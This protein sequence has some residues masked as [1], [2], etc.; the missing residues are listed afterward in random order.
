MV[1]RNLPRFPLY[2]AIPE[3]ELES[4]TEDIIAFEFILR[5]Y[6][7]VLTLEISPLQIQTIWKGI[8]C[9]VSDFIAST[10][11]PSLASAYNL[12]F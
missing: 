8:S 10:N 5:V 9:S 7:T 4:F 2:M 6:V 3:E 1:F 12:T 11:D